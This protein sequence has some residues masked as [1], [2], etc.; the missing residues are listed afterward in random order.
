MGGGSRTGGECG[1]SR[2]LGG[3]GDSR[4]GG[5]CGDSR[6]DGGCGGSLRLLKAADV[7]AYVREE[8]I[9]TGYRQSLGYL[10]CVKRCVYTLY[11][12][13]HSKR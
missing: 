11:S 2:T 10:G 3:C 8:S 7:P 6:T 4:T 9:E 5:G 12:S 13:V 1:G